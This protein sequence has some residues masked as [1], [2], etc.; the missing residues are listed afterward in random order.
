MLDCESDE[1]GRTFLARQSFR[2]PMHLS[3][4]YWEGN[5]LIINAVNPTAGLFPG[6]SIDL[7]LRVRKDASVVFTSPS[8]SRI[9]RGRVGVV[10]VHQHF[11]V[12]EGGWLDV[13]PELLIPHKG[14]H[15]V[16]NTV[17]HLKSRSGLFF[18]EML[19]PGRLAFGEA[20]D[21]EKIEMR[22]ELRIAEEL[23]ALD[24]YRLMPTD[25]S[26]RA[27]RILY[28]N[29][30]YAACFLFSEHLPSLVD[31][32]QLALSHPQATAAISYFPQG[33][34]VIRIIAGDSIALKRIIFAIR[35]FV[36]REIGNRLPILRK[37]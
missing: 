16:Q 15:Y 30:Y 25:G 19:A 29:S 32:Q 14:S 11:Q 28:E 34:A 13:F 12:E 6:D 3:K 5:Y 7:D 22:T 24:N 21:F 17:I 37:Q 18:T 8:A 2:A 9:Y 31:F 1:E 26:I 33:V 36:Y 20:F 35:A 10:R 23:V 4:P 27:L